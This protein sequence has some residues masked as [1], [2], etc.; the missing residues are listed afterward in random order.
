MHIPGELD[1]Q[2]EFFP[3]SSTPAPAKQRIPGE[4]RLRLRHDQVILGG[5]A[6][7]IGMTVVFAWG[8]ERGK[9]LA[10]LERPL[11]QPHEFVPS[12]VNRV[13]SHKPAVEVPAEASRVETTPVSPTRVVPIAE[14]GPSRYAVQVVTYS[15]VQ[16]A[17]SELERL[18]KSGEEAFVRESQGHTVLYVGP[19]KS[20]AMAREKRAS[21]MSRYQDCF[22]RSL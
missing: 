1:D 13:M 16:L 10:R 9:Q 11:L 22:V 14:D 15:R 18:Q 19:F 4:I 21:L 3:V 6:A 20:A 7:L 2:L 8:V 5:I 12:S 17:R